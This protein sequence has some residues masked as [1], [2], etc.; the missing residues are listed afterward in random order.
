MTDHAIFPD[1]KGKSIFITGGGS[2]IGAAL[3]EGFL[4]QGAKVAF[5][6]R[7]DARASAT[8]WSARQA[9]ARCS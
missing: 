7:S 3:T 8:G 1:L 6:Q 2:G 4:R 5:V 9:T